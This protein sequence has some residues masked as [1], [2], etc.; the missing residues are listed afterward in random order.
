MSL[1]Q[2]SKTQFKINVYKAMKCALQFSHNLAVQK[3]T[4]SYS[5]ITTVMTKRNS[6]RNSVPAINVALANLVHSL[7]NHSRRNDKCC[8]GQLGTFPSQSQQ[9]KRAARSLRSAPYS[10]SS[11]RLDLKVGFERACCHVMNSAIYI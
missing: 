8:P 4:M 2:I 7:A 10:Q 9:T 5:Q 6:G 11:S 3:R 1:T